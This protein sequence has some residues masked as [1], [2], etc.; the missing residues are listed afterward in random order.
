MVNGL[1]GTVVD[2]VARQVRNV[3]LTPKENVFIRRIA[4]VFV[5]FL[6]DR[7]FILVNWVEHKFKLINLKSGNLNY[8]SSALLFINHIHSLINY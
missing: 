1:N 2:V 3:G 8:N 4:G 5:V 7:L 6:L